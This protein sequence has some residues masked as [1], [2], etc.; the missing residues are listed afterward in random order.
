[1]IKDYFKWFDQS[2]VQ[3]EIIDITEFDGP[4]DDHGYVITARVLKS[5]MLPL[6]GCLLIVSLS[7]LRCFSCL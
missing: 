4:Y 1:M 3:G 6:M 5:Y 7:I 2:Y